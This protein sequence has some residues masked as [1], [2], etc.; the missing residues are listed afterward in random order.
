MFQRTH[1]VSSW[2]SFA[3]TGKKETKEKIELNSALFPWLCWIWWSLFY[4]NQEPLSFSL[5]IS[6]LA[7]LYYLCS[8]LRVLKSAD[9]ILAEDT[10]HSGKLLQYYNINTP[11]VSP[12][13][14]APFIAWNIE[15][16]TFYLIVKDLLL[17]LSYHKFNESQREATILRKLQQGQT[18]A[19]ISDAG[20]PG[21]SDPGAELVGTSIS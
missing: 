20:T 8:A 6:S 2:S 5:Q 14:N 18:V 3:P 13:F 16:R 12:L 11:L 9:V 17:Q 19:L 1:N 7:I 10:R 4:F 21:I 15:L